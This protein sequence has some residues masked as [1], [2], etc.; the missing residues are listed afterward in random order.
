MSSKPRR[1]R[2]CRRR[3]A[4]FDPHPRIALGNQVELLTTLERR[5]ELLSD[6]GVEVVV[7]RFTPDSAGDAGAVR[8]RDPEAAGR[9]GRRRGCEL[10]FRPG[11]VRISTR[12]GSSAST[13]GPFRSSRASPRA[14]SG[15]SSAQGRSRRPRMLGRPHEVEKTVVSGRRARRDAGVSDGEPRRAVGGDRRPTG[16]TP[17]WSASI[18][19]RSRSASTRTTAGR[20][21][22]SGVPPRLRRKPLRRPPRRGALACVSATNAPS[23]RNRS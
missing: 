21:A 13:C 22:G 6:L 12:F 10:P 15:S 11:P 19:L 18:G 3:S 17:A 9:R 5:V 7:V 8:R 23:T 4:T 1:P 2:D 20:S 16:S 14:G